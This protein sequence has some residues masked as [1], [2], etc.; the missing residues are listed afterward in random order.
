M[1]ASE[2]LCGLYPP[3][4]RQRWGADIGRE[5]AESGIR[6]WPDTIFGAGRLWMRP[7]D[8]PETAPGQ[9]RLVVVVALFA[10]TAIVSL[11][12]R[13]ADTA[14]RLTADVQRPLTSLW[15]VPV[16]LGL[17]LAAPWPSWRWAAL[18]ALAG[19]VVLGLVAPTVAFLAMLLIARS[20]LVEQP[21]GVLR[22]ALVAY[23]WATLGFMAYSSCR[24]LARVARIAHLP[25]A[26]RLS[27]GAHLIGVGLALAAAQNLLAMMGTGPDPGSLTVVLVLV[28]VAAGTIRAGRDLQGQAG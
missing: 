15:V 10:L 23:Y 21:A 5:V 11:L 22:V 6:G 26:R 28:L 13:A 16:G 25:S 2:V 19:Q 14:G 27:A 12:L 9:T 18:R 1:K 3:A 17:W 20:A 4:V 24:L 7:G 8:W